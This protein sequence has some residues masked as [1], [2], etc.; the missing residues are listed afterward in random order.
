MPTAQPISN[1]RRH[2]DE[3]DDDHGG[4]DA[5][6][7]ALAAGGPLSPRSRTRQFGVVPCVTRDQ[8]RHDDPERQEDAGNDVGQR[9]GLV[10][11]VGAAAGAVNTLAGGGTLLIYPALLACGLPP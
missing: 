5:V 3:D 9:P 10:A 1:H 11:L 4:R 7:P 8:Q 6:D 2:G